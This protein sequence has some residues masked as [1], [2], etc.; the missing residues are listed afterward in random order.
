[1]V[2]GCFG[3]SGQVINS[4]KSKISKMLPPRSKKNI[5]SLDS[6]LEFQGGCWLVKEC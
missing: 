4:R 5:L 3:S 2:E 1:M 6:L